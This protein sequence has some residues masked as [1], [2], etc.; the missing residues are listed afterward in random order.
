MA[1][2]KTNI[3]FGLVFIPITLSPCIKANNINFNLLDKKTKSRVKY[4]KTCEKCN[5]KEIKQSDIIKGYEYDK[6]KY[7]TFSQEDFEKL[8]TEQDKNITIISFSPLNEFDPIIFERSFYCIPNK[9]EKAY[10]LIL[11]AMEDEKKVAVAKT[12]ISNK[13]TLVILR[14]KNGVLILS[15]LYYFEELIQRPQILKEKINEKELNIAKTIIKK[16]SSKFDYESFEDEYKERLMQA[17]EKKINGEKISKPK[18]KKQLKP[19]NL[20]DALKKSL[21]DTNTTKNKKT[22]KDK[23][24]NAQNKILKF[25]INN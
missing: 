13:E 17:I 24:E 3:S 22:K 7:V 8:K 23:K 16:M 18:T 19:I 15:T 2:Y 10:G 25:E 1:N 12:I 6:N 9:S 11:K 21:E 20:M 14:A 4:I 5:K